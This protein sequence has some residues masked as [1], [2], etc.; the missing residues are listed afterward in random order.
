MP[1]PALQRQVEPEEEE[2]EEET[3]QTKAIANPV[4]PSSQ[5]QESSQVPP[6]VHEVLYSP[7]YSLDPETRSFMESRFGHDF[8][9]VRVHTDAKAAES[10]HAIVFGTGQYAPGTPTGQRLLAHELT[11]VVQQSHQPTTKP[12]EFASAPMLSFQYQTLLSRL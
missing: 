6:I 9:S 12:Y 5:N 10:A 2:E 11:H 1:E 7:G 4:T 8:S 3:I